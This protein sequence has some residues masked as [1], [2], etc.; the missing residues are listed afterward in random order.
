MPQFEWD[1]TMED[2]CSSEKEIQELREVASL[3]CGMQ[4][5][6]SSPLFKD[7]LKARLM[8]GAGTEA[9]GSPGKKSGLFKLKTFCSRKKNGLLGS[10]VFSAAAVL[11]LIVAV[12]FFYNQGPA[13]YNPEIADPSRP[14]DPEI[15][16]SSGGRNAEEQFPESGG[17]VIPPAKGEN[18]DPPPVKDPPEENPAG[19]EGVSIPEDLE[20]TAPETGIVN[21]PQPVDPA[22]PGKPVSGEEGALKKEPDFEALKNGKALALVGKVKPASV[23]YGVKKEDRPDPADNTRCLWEPRKKTLSNFRGE[24]GTIGTETW[25]MEIL[26]NEGFMVKSADQLQVV[27]QETQ[28][29]IYAEI[30]YKEQSSDR[31]NPA[32]V[33]LFGAEEGIMSYY[34]QEQGE[35]AEPGFYRLLSP[36]QAFKQVQELQWYTSQPRMSFT[37]QEVSLIYYQFEVEEGGGK[38][39]ITLPA[40]C[41]V[42]MSLSHGDAF[43]VYVPA[44]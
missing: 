16:I 34:Y 22:G 39:T 4:K 14:R 13:V 35:Y 28:K 12:T 19:H 2:L 5:A 1:K 37:F 31:Q 30:V 36:T 43:K 20:A 3:L 23:Y 26:L 18:E 41:Y 27:P 15:Y 24:G 25:A 7:N 38:K 29:G 9:S 44:V 10:P 6:Q 32:L 40:Y 21:D 42:G 11:L 33:L 8:E 17:A